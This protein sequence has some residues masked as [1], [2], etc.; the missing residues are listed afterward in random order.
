MYFAKRENAQKLFVTLAG[1]PSNKATVNRSYLQSLV[2]HRLYDNEKSF[3]DRKD[4]KKLRIDAIVLDLI[5][6]NECVL[7]KSLPLI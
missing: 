1:T 2:N 6:S 7:N 5:K 3:D 4:M